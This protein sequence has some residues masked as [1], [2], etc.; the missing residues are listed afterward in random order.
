MIYLA[1]FP[2]HPSNNKSVMRAR[3]PQAAEGLSLQSLKLL[4]PPLTRVSC[5]GNQVPTC[6]SPLF[7][8]LPPGSQGQASVLVL[9]DA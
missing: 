2:W 5:Q 4:T 6:G 1:Y 3:K 8:C 9:L 7:L